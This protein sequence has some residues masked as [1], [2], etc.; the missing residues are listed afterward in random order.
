MQDVSKLHQT[1]IISTFLG[2]LNI[3]LVGITIY[4]FWLL[5]LISMYIN[6]RQFSKWSL[7]L[8]RNIIKIWLVHFADIYIF[9]MIFRFFWLQA[10][11]VVKTK[12]CISDFWPF[13]AVWRNQGILPN[14]WIPSFLHTFG[15]IY[16]PRCWRC[17]FS[18]N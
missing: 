16:H 14:C 11:D 15:K 5:F 17:S 4:M 1:D 18:F 8:F 3:N 2:F 13:F 12:F 6:L 10:Y 7:I 9:R